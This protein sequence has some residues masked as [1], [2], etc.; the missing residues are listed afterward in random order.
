VALECENLKNVRGRILG[1]CL[2]AIVVR[3]VFGESRS[4]REQAFAFYEARNY[5][6]ARAAYASLARE[7]REDPDIEFHLGR[8][9]LWFDDSAEALAQLEKLAARMP[10]EARVQN[11]LEMPMD[12]PRKKLLCSRNWVGRANA[13]PPTNVR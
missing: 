2:L 11:A 4:G 3:P 5:S 8:L 6:A 12:W 7:T 1:V 10:E 13:A 9:A